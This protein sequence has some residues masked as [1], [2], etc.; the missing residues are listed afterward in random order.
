MLLEQHKNCGVWKQCATWNN[1]QRRN[2]WQSERKRKCL[3]WSAEF[4]SFSSSWRECEFILSTLFCRSFFSCS[5][6]SSNSINFCS[7][8]TQ[9][10]TWDYLFFDHNNIHNITVLHYNN[11]WTYSWACN[12]TI[13]NHMCSSLGNI[14]YKEMMKLFMKD[15]NHFNCCDWIAHEKRNKFPLLF[16][17]YLSIHDLTSIGVVNIIAIIFFHTFKDMLSKHSS[18]MLTAHFQ[19]CL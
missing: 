4:L 1:C 8:R 12:S 5:C 16:Y 6:E 17:I 15:E 7:L 13:L 18:N 2:A 11:S 14:W 10:S 3:P 19:I 9:K